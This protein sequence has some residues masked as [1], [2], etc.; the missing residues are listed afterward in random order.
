MASALISSRQSSTLMA[1]L[2]A[3]LQ[4]CGSMA[5]RSPGMQPSQMLSSRYLIGHI[6]LLVLMQAVAAMQTETEPCL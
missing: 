5:S 6:C 3:T 2:A 4:V 1:A